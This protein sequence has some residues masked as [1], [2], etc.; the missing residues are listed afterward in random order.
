MYRLLDFLEGMV[1]R[2]VQLFVAL[3]AL[4]MECV[5]HTLPEKVWQDLNE[6]ASKKAFGFARCSAA[7]VICIS[8]ILFLLA[9]LLI[10]LLTG[11]ICVFYVVST[12]ITSDIWARIGSRI[13][14]TC[15]GRSW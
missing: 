15:M 8:I 4:L 13:T 9:L 11:L 14:Q 1:Y 7:L 5:M 12:I 2:A 6:P 10:S 3:P